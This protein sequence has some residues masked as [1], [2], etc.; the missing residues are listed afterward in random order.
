LLLDALT[1]RREAS[2]GHSGVVIDHLVR[3]R[4]E[5]SSLVVRV[6]AERSQDSEARG[7]RIVAITRIIGW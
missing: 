6:D 5:A 2:V 4:V 3:A 1:I 7:L